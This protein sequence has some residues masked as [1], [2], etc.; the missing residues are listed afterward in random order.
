MEHLAHRAR[1]G[2]SVSVTQNL[3]VVTLTPV[4]E[5]P[6]EYYTAV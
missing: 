2:M 1:V 3:S 5:S 6:A 4:Y